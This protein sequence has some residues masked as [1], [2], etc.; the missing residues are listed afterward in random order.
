MIGTV[1]L[2]HAQAHT[3]P[4]LWVPLSSSV[5]ALTE[6]CVLQM[7]FPHSG[8]HGFD[9]I[10]PDATVLTP[11]KDVVVAM[12][13]RETEL[14]NDRET[15]ELLDKI[16]NDPDEQ[17]GQEEEVAEDNETVEGKDPVYVFNGFFMSMRANFVAADA[18]GIRYRVGLDVPKRP[19]VGPGR[20]PWLLMDG[21][22]PDAW[23]T[24]E[25]LPHALLPRSDGGERNA[26]AS[27]GNARSARPRR[28]ACRAPPPASRTPP[29]TAAAAADT[30]AILR[31]HGA[32]RLLA[33]C[34]PRSTST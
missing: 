17:D 31:I 30:A 29:V 15:Q 18:E 33:V 11:S 9:Q 13:K 3:A 7:L 23:W 2:Q 20:L 8:R 25:L 27:A 19:A 26:L 6:C 5:R 32:A 21:A 4:L 22:D 14:R 1:T 28:D 16:Q 12:L 24:G 10:E 34:A